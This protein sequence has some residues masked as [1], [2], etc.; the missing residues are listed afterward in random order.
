M[1]A[2]RKLRGHED[3]LH[4]NH[5]AKFRGGVTAA[6]DLRVNHSED[7]SGI[8]PG[9]LQ[10]LFS[11]GSVH[12]QQ[13]HHDLRHPRNEHI[14]PGTGKMLYGGGS[15]PKPPWQPNLYGGGSVA[16]PSWQPGLFKG[17]SP[18]RMHAVDDLRFGRHED[19]DPEMGKMLF[20]G[21]SPNRQHAVD[22]TRM[23][24][25]GEDSDLPANFEPLA[26]GGEADG[27]SSD[28]KLAAHECVAALKSGD[29]MK[30]LRALKGLFYLM[31]DDGD[32]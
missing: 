28:E 23:G 32:E 24:H 29:A 16:K 3:A 30:F 2:K 19:I 12:K 5:N 15:V 13:G 27:F 6:E 31:D 21:G 14:K 17:G 18:H 1:N 10:M 8:R 9:V 22:D 20:R 11:G 25:D 7:G 26:E 4:R